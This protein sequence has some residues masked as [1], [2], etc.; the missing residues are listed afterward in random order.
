MQSGNTWPGSTRREQRSYRHT[1]YW[2]VYSSANQLIF[3]V[4]IKLHFF[5]TYKQNNAVLTDQCFSNS[6]N[7]F[8]FSMLLRR[9]LVYIQ[10]EFLVWIYFVFGNINER[11]MFCPPVSS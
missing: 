11:N 6:Q 3:L 8:K 4:K 7:I 10:L 1:G 5:K 9:Y 2:Y